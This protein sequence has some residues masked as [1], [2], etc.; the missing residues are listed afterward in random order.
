MTKDQYLRNILARL[1]VDNGQQSP[2]RGVQAV[3]RPSLLNW[4][5]QY[6]V[7]MH[8]S[9][10]F[11]KG[12]AIHGGTDIDIFAS[13]SEQVTDALLVIYTSL[14]NRLRDDG[15]TPRMQ[16]VSIGLKINGYSVDVIPARRQA[17]SGDYHSLYR[18]KAQTWS[19]TNVITHINTV[20]SSG[21][22]E[23]IMIMKAWR[24]QKGLVFPSFYLELVT[25]EACRGRKTGAL[26]D[27]VW[28]TL[29]YVKSNI[30]T[31][32]FIDP[33]NTNNRISDDLTA[34]EKQALATAAGIARQAKHWSQ[35]VV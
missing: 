8:P 32:I 10:S 19:Q 30:T 29:E 12:T 3:L 28:A 15:F 14:F 2:V 6:L 27:N 31:A 4:A 17:A 22:S 34:T 23:E 13:I 26:A 35:V 18:R 25:I 11:A 24:E 21:R 33:S 16:N 7:S 20:R 1:R 5:G 9:G